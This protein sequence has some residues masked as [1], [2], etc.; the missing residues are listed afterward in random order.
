MIWIN[1]Q[2][3]LSLFDNKC[4]RFK[5]NTLFDGVVRYRLMIILRNNYFIKGKNASISITIK[6]MT[7]RN[8]CVFIVIK[9][10][11]RTHYRFIIKRCN[12]ASIGFHSVQIILSFDNLIHLHIAI[13]RR[14]SDIYFWLQKKT[15]YCH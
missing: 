7:R 9:F 2:I 5:M 3:N 11:Y 6:R 1:V 13:K 14:L 4:K 10:L 15:C 12:H 8:N